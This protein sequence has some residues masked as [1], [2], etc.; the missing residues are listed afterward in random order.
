MARRKKFERVYLL[1]LL[2]PAIF[3]FSVYQWLT[4]SDSLL[5][6]D[7]TGRDVLRTMP[8]SFWVWVWLGI[9]GT[10]IFSI[11]TYLNH[12]GAWIGKYLKGS[13][14]VTIA[15]IILA[16]ACLICPWIK[17]MQ[18][19]VDNNFNR[20][21]PQAYENHNTNSLSGHLYTMYNR[22]DGILSA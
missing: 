6:G 16:L 11:A 14:G 21:K 5:P 20:P 9:L 3:I 19:K 1:L 17:A 18:A 4:N 2:I 8:D 12:T 10:V 22:T 13:T 15:F 7:L